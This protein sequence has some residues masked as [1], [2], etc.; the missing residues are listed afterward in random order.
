MFINV[1]C[2]LRNKLKDKKNGPCTSK[3][4]FSIT[5]GENH[6]IKPESCQEAIRQ[7]EVFINAY[8][9][10]T[11]INILSDKSDTLKKEAA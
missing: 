2:G 5:N 1:E 8:R 10:L 9:A 4:H 7:L 6:S 11:N 3:A